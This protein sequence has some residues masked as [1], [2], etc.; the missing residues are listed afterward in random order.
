MKTT[1]HPKIQQQHLARKAIVYLR[2]STPQQVDRNLASQ[3]LQY[4]MA[5][6]ARKFGWRS[7]EVID[8]DL[9]SSAAVGASRREG[10]E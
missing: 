3:Q 5:E 10:F 7:V 8:E 6:R 1:S 9:G 2:Q 4:A